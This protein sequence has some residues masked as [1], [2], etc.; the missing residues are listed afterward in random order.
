MAA[1]Y[2]TAETLPNWAYF[3]VDN[4]MCSRKEALA[5]LTAYCTEHGY[6]EPQYVDGAFWG[7]PPNAVMPVQIPEKVIRASLVDLRLR[8]K[9]HRRA[10]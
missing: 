7:F 3:W 8:F 1:P 6:S 10:L 5:A 4:K 2:F 9:G